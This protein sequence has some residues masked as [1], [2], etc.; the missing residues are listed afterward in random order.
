MKTYPRNGLS[1]VLE[2]SAYTSLA[3]LHLMNGEAVTLCYGLLTVAIILRLRRQ[4][5][6]TRKNRLNSN[7]SSTS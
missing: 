4:F 6:R 2:L 7:D 1:L 5:R 3:A